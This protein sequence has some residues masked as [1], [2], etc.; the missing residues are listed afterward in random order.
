MA[1]AWKRSVKALFITSSTTCVAF[2]S[3]SMS[4][5]IPIKAF[6]YYA[7]I[8]IPVNFFLI[9]IMLPPMLVFYEK[10][11]SHRL[12]CINCKATERKNKYNNDENIIVIRHS[13]SE[14][15]FGGFWNGMVRKLRWLI[16]L[17]ACGW[18]GYA[19]YKSTEIKSLSE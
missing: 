8:I 7:A 13:L 17:L 10:Y 18:T 9:I 12:C 2:L 1:F 3:N 4:K 5:V 16:V 19:C 14:R 6:G 15:F 11:L